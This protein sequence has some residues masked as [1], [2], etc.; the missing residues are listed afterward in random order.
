MTNSDLKVKSFFQFEKHIK[1]KRGT[2]FQNTYYAQ[3]HFPKHFSWSIMNT[4]YCHF[5]LQKLT[6][7]SPDTPV[8]H[9]SVPSHLRQSYFNLSKGTARRVLGQIITGQLGNGTDKNLYIFYL[10]GSSQNDDSMDFLDQELK[11][12]IKWNLIVFLETVF[13]IAKF[14]ICQAVYIKG[15]CLR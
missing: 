3:H 8:H 12:K 6:V 2:K 10:I 9:L 1:Q 15:L 7:Q 5:L 11:V 4:S 13:Y 14:Y